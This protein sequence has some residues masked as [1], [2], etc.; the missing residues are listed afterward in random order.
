MSDPEE[1][2]WGPTLGEQYTGKVVMVKRG[3]CS[4]ELKVIQ[5]T[6]RLRV[7]KHVVICGLIWLATTG[8]RHNFAAELLF[9][10]QTKANIIN[11]EQR[12]DNTNKIGRQKNKI[13]TTRCISFFNI[14]NT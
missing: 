5:C 9:G 1:L 6:R 7:S 13:C 2:C 8:M 4:Y 3:T 11:E 10:N 12:T 14:S